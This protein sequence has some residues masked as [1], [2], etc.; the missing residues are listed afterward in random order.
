VIVGFYRGSDLRKVEITHGDGENVVREE[1]YFDG[2]QVVF[3]YRDAK[4]APEGASAAVRREDR[5]Y[6]AKGRLM[7]WV[8]SDGQRVPQ[9]YP[10]FPVAERETLDGLKPVLAA[11]A[12]ARGTF[13]PFDPPSALLH[14]DWARSLE[15]KATKLENSTLAHVLM[16]GERLDI[17]DSD[18]QPLNVS[19]WSAGVE[20]SCGRA[21]HMICGYRYFLAVADPGEGGDMV[22]YNL[23][24]F[25]TIERAE[26]QPT[27]DDRVRLQFVA[28]NYPAHVFEHWTG[29]DRERGTFLL[30]IG[31]DSV[32][33]RRSRPTR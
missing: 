22:V 18:K 1:C 3:R 26:W 11:L 20:T 6:F 4:A 14:T 24:E 27:S 16:Y 9:A 8:G 2:G 28:L 5:Y 31:T 21:G 23:G 19:L 13:D 33:V 32:V 25:G 7:R 30:N 10:S 17:K 15:V 29:V 12:S